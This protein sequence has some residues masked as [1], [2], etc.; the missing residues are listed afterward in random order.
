MKIAMTNE[1]IVANIDTLCNDVRVKVEHLQSLYNL[2]TS[3]RNK[4]VV[5]SPRFYN[6]N[7]LAELNAVHQKHLLRRIREKA[8]TAN[9]PLNLSEF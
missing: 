1:E 5:I 8:K 6:D 2:L 7:E 9:Y 3:L 4:E